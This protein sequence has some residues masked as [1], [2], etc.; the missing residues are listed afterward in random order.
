MAGPSGYANTENQIKRFL[1]DD[2]VLGGLLSDDEANQVL[3]SD[4]RT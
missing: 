1:E 2:E 4:H 3:I